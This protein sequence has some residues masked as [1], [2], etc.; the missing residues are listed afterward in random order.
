MYVND[1]QINLKRKQAVEEDIEGHLNNKGDLG[2]LFIIKGFWKKE[3]L[4]KTES[5]IKG[6][7]TVIKY[8]KHSLITNG[9]MCKMYILLPFFQTPQCYFSI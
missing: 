4:D 2:P 1:K 9:K 6:V 8:I 5:L 7:C 3:S